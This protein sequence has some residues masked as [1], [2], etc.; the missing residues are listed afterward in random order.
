M[1]VQKSIAH[2]LQNTNTPYCD[3]FGAGTE[4]QTLHIYGINSIFMVMN[5]KCLIK[6]PHRI[7]R[8]NDVFDIL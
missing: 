1:T 8:W 4:H 3:D 5:I 7:G 6:M 2:S